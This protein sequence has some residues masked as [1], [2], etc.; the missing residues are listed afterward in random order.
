M[1]MVLAEVL[2]QQGVAQRNMREVLWW[3]GGLLLVAMVLGGG[4]AALR[5]RVLPKQEEPPDQV[6][7]LEDL[8]RMQAAGELSVEEFETLRARL[9]AEMGGVGGSKQAPPGRTGESSAG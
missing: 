9:I 3:G 7:S 2:G 8:R 1:A 4:V 6:W 5:R